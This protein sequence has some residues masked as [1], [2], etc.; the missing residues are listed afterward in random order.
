MS[1]KTIVVS[2][3]NPQFYDIFIDATSDFGNPF[4]IGGEYDGTRSDVTAKYQKYLLSRMERDERFAN[5]VE[6]LRGKKIGFGM[7]EQKIACDVIVRYL[8]GEFDSVIEE[9]EEDD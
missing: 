5:L 1:S 6:T 2:S 7:S 3:T 4:K 8:N 9:D